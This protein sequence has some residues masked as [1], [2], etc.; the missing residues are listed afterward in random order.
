M[1]LERL[2]AKQ[3][4]LNDTDNE[5]A[6]RLNL[7]RSTWQAYRS[8]RIPLQ[9]KVAKRVLVV[10]PDL[11]PEALSFLLGDASRLAQR[12]STEATDAA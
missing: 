11:E 6:E 5:F 12:D 4:E 1:L 2:I 7:P 9:D 3:A 8:G 10:F